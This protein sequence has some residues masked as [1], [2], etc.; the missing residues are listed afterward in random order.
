MAR[1]GLINEVSTNPGFLLLMGALVAGTTALLI[2]DLHAE[3]PS[4]LDIAIR[5]ATVACWLVLLVAGLVGRRRQRGRRAEEG[6]D[7]TDSS[8]PKSSTGRRP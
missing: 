4:T 8:D 3:A 6:N 1:R 5:G 2:R 7:P